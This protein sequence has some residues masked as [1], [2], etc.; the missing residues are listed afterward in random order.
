MPAAAIHQPLCL[1]LLSSSSSPFQ[2]FISKRLLGLGGSPSFLNCVAFSHLCVTRRRPL[3]CRLFQQQ[4]YH[5][6]FVPLS[7]LG[8]P[9]LRLAVRLARSSW[10]YLVLFI[11]G[12]GQFANPAFGVERVVEGL[13][14][15]LLLPHSVAVAASDR[16]TG[17]E[18]DSVLHNDS[19]R[20]SLPLINARNWR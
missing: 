19:A 11:A 16:P 15:S 17:N 2:S 6:T 12:R 18:L 13:P 10:L 3:K 8:F 1:S 14:R 20:S 4:F 7:A 5:Y 9:N